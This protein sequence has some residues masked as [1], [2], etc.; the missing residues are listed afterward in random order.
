MKKHVFILITIYIFLFT[1]DLKS[2][3]CLP[4]GIIFTTQEEIDNFKQTTPIAQK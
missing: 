2:Q 4:E 1:A 3:P